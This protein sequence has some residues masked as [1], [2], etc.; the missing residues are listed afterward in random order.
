LLPS[1][2]TI[3]CSNPVI[4]EAGMLDMLKKYPSLTCGVHGL[5]GVFK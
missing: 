5:L 1:R 2:T 3:F 4:N